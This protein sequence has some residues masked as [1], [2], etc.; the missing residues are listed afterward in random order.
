MPRKIR[1]WHR[2]LQ[3]W[4]ARYVAGAPAPFR[5]PLDLRKLSLARLRVTEAMLK[6]PWGGTLSYAQLARLAL[7][8]AQAARAAATACRL[9]PLPVLVPCHRI[10]YQ[11]GGLG[12]F[13]AGLHWKR[14]L[15]RHEK[16][17]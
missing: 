8:R 9:N 7:G 2:A 1:L 13:S 14:R 3:A 15:L 6:I 16:S 4:L 11:N 12:G 17:L 10:V 5:V